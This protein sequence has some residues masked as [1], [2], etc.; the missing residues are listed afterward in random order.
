MQELHWGGVKSAL[1]AGRLIARGRPFAL[2]IQGRAAETLKR[3]ARPGARLDRQMLGLVFSN[4]SLTTLPGLMM[5]SLGRRY[6]LVYDNLGSG[7]IRVRFETE[8]GT[9]A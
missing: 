7:G 8:P 3:V 9:P 1:T 5:Y 4:F 2:V 6:H